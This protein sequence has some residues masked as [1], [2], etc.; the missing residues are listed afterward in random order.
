MTDRM[1]GLNPQILKSFVLFQDLPAPQLAQVASIARERRFPPKHTVFLEGEKGTYVVLIVSGIVKISRSSSDGRVKTL[2]LLRA[3]D[4]FG[5]M[6]LFLPGHERSAT[7]EALTECRVIT[8]EQPDFEKLL[9]DVPAISLHIIQTLA[10]RLQAANRQIKT[11]AL[12]DAQSKLA[13]LLL[14]L[15]D[16]FAAPGSDLPVIPLT[17]QELADLAGLS[18]ETTTRLLNALAKKGLVALSSRQVRLV[19][20]GG[21]KKLAT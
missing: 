11:L 4:F 8:L 20:P 17:H 16:E 9:R 21:L 2:A 18:R 1:A 3:N 5:E 15:K 13:D 12:G 19:S 7:A 6:A 10:H 14:W